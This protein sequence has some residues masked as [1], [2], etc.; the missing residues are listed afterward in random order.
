MRLPAR[1]LLLGVALGFVVTCL[2]GRRVSREDYHQNFLRFTEWI[3]PETKYYPTIDE[4]MAIV[5]HRARPDQILVIIGGNSVLRGVGQP[6][7]HL[8]SKRLQ[9][10]LGDGYCVINFAF[11]S[12]LP[13]DGAAVLAES[14]RKEYPRQ[15]YLANAA[16]TQGAFPAG[17]DVYRFVFW[18][19]QAKG[20][21]IDDP[22]RAAAMKKV[23][24]NP[25]WAFYQVG[26]LELK[27]RSWLDRF[28][29]FQDFW[30]YVTYQKFGTVWG[31]YFPGMVGFQAP[32]NFL[33]PRKTY[34]DPE[35]DFLAMPMRIRYPAANIDAELLNV[36][37]CSMYAFNN[38]DAQGRWQ[39]YEP[40]WELFREFIVGE[41]PQELKKR[42]LILMSHSSPYFIQ[43]LP[44]DERQRDGLAY[45]EA[46]REWKAGG[47]DSIEYGQD[48]TVD[49]YGDRTHLTWH[50]GYKLADTVA[51]KIREMSQELGYLKHESN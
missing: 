15:I 22:V 39:I 11:N 3:S 41:F 7:D 44:A 9:E 18:G 27:I 32:L 4:M 24:E 49:D 29:H 42:T 5:R 6:P 10:N 34:A 26:L 20:L 33:A 21:L 47:Y 31:Y 19:A 37:G 17:S 38:K 25:A 28:M 8:W 1:T 16:P 35:P 46:V 30:D 51:A 43:R 12:S 2:L 40:V 36:R 48:Y 45:A 14:L 50:G 13:T 23:D